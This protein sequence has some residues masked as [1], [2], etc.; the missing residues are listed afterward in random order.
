MGRLDPASLR[1]ELRDAL[2]GLSPGQLTGV[3]KIPSGYAILQ[4][5]PEEQSTAGIGMSS[6]QMLPLTGR[7]SVRYTPDISGAVDMELAFRKVPKAD[8]WNRDFQAVCETR[9][10]AL[11]MAVQQMEKKWP[12]NVT[13]TTAEGSPAGHP[14]KYLI[15]PTAFKCKEKIGGFVDVAHAAGHDKFAMA[16]A[17]I[18]DDFPPDR[19]LDVVP[20]SYYHSEP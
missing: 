5:M 8:D 3:I 9:K 7:G 15:S 11:A 6:S 20:P 4:I 10:R 17:H 18:V 16:P 2:Q 14:M 1:P 19:L 12:K 13:D